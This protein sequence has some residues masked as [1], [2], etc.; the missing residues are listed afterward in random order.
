[1][2]GSLRVFWLFQK[3]GLSKGDGKLFSPKVSASYDLTL[4]HC[5]KF[6]ADHKALFDI[7][8]RG[9]SGEFVSKAFVIWSY[10][11]NQSGSPRSP[12]PWGAGNWALEGIS[13]LTI[14]LRRWGLAF[15]WS[16]RFWQRV[17]AIMLPGKIECW[18]SL[19]KLTPS[20]F[21]LPALLSQW[22]LVPGPI[23]KP[24]PTR[25]LAKLVGK[26]SWTW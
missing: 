24:I 5:Y 23:Q 26:C 20:F 19:S 6:L 3:D 8:A 16:W 2:I 15:Q 25:I 17:W 4:P 22:T 12:F 21:V 11:C 1:M 18:V 9:K 7:V 14:C 10:K 13:I